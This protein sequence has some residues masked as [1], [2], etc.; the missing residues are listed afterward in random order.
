VLVVQFTHVVPDAPHAAAAVPVAHIPPLQ[1]PP[2]HV[3]PDAPPHAFVQAPPEH[4]GV[5][6]LHAPQAA[7][8]VPH[9]LL[10]C[11]PVCSQLFPLQQPVAHD[12]ALQTHAP[13]AQA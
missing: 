12:A 3:D 4:V 9:V 5:S 1:Q 13:A 6:P 7:P 10:F 8:A 2:T 11:E